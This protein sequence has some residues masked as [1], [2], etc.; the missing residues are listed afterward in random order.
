MRMGRE[1]E[2]NVRRV[3]REGAGEG[4]AMTTFEDHDGQGEAD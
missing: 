4:D 3:V 2:N 1:R